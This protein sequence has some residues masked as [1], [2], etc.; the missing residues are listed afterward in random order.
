[1]HPHE[2]RL[3]RRTLMRGALGAT[4]AA[5]VAGVAAGCAN[6]TTAVGSGD[7]GGASPAVQKYVVAKPTGPDGLPLPRTDNAVTWAI[8]DDNPPVK[9]GLQSEGGTLNVYNY[10]DYIWPGLVKRFEKAY[11]CKVKIATYNSSDEAAAKLRPAPSTSTS[12][13]A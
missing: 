11:N 13:S 4:A 1:M 6:T 7:G 9:D 10:A 2:H 3:N 12:W 8:T 5:G